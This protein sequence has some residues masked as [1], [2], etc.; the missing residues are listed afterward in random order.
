M[1]LPSVRHFLETRRAA[2]YARSM[3]AAIV[4]TS[5][6]FSV[7]GCAPRAG[8]VRPEHPLLFAESGRPALVAPRDDRVVLDDHAP[9]DDAEILAARQRVALIASQSV[10]PGPLVVN[11]VP[12]RMDCSGVARA[13]YARAGF[14]L[15]TIELGAAVNDTRMLF[16][17]VRRSGS[18]RRS[19]PLPGDLVF[20]DDTWDQ[21]GNG[22][23]DDPLSHVAIVERVE[24]D[25]TVL[26]VHRVGRS[27]VRARM[28]LEHPH[29]RH[30]AKGRPLNHYLRA[31]TTSA[32]AQT[33]A[34][35]FVAFGSVP[36][37]TPRL[38]ASR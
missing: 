21:N 36:L 2:R 24:A 11:G 38:V 7:G 4:V 1:A 15:G 27:V 33:T 25:G 35:L 18:L 20:F 5:L 8:V 9:M 12:F 19:N 10:G 29:D 32:P 22:L 37:S 26:L 13:I 16:E 3:R 28:N 34:E 14:D 6:F 17:V 30:D 23:R 31:A